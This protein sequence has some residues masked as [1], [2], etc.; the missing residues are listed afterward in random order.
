MPRRPTLIA[1]LALVVIATG[2]MRAQVVGTLGAATGH[3]TYDDA[4]RATV[5][6]LTPA[7]TFEGE[8]TTLSA[9]GS[10]TRFAG[11]LWSAHAAAA[12]SRF[13]QARGPVRGE[14]AAQFEANSHRGAL[15]TSF[16]LAQARGHLI[17]D[18]ARGLW[19]GGGAGHVWRS[20]TGATV[21]RADAGAWTLLGD[22][23]IRLTATHNVVSMSERSVSVQPNFEVA[24]ASPS[25][26]NES[27]SQST[28]RY[29]DAEAHVT[30]ARGRVAFDAG[31]GRRSMKTGPDANTWLVG[32][33]LELT[34]RLAVV[35]S[36]GATPVDL[37]QG[38]PGGR[39]ATI[40]LRVTTRAGDALEMRSR[41]RASARDLNTWREADGTVLLVVHA[42]RARRVELMGDFTDW[43]PL[44]LRRE[45][46][47]YFA[48][49]I[50]LPAGSY[51]VNVRVDGGM[52]IAPPGT[53]P[54]ADEYN[55]AAGLLV[56]G[57]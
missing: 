31:A 36:A 55:G 28:V 7:V 22:A 9:A 32:G 54:V 5:V 44:S 3:V 16:L 49:R 34:D 30:W 13:T 24:V 20:P 1:S 37:A 10:F 18:G 53:T 38:L 26:R 12:G 33:S 41:S 35:G 17:D 4:A 8:R 57:S 21:F 15:R 23:T 48:V 42:P 39:Y 45:A 19:L 46:D 25:A 14:L 2:T 29:L 50:R 47:D 52:W 11:G 6:S 43:H 40:A 51:R 56:I 27:L